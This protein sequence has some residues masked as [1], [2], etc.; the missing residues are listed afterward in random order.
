M[1]LDPRTAASLSKLRTIS[2]VL[3]NAIALPG[4]R[5]RVGLDPVLGL[6]PGGGDMIG[7]ILSIY[8]VWESAQLG[9]PPATVTKMVS[10]L[11]LDAALG[12]F[13]VVGD[14]FDAT[15]KANSKNLSLLEAHLN[16]PNVEKKANPAFV[17]LLLSGFLMLAIALAALTGV[18]IALVWNALFQ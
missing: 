16:A 14:F 1:Q 17:L 8:M 13:P 2:H 5:Y 15:W 10:N 6:L 9:V 18:I 12:S 3:D 4:T 11:V 7:A